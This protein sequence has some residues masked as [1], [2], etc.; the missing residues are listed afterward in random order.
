MPC[1]FESSNSKGYFTFVAFIRKDWN[2]SERWWTTT[3][4]GRWTSLSS[5]AAAGPE[6]LPQLCGVRAPTTLSRASRSPCQAEQP[7]AQKRSHSYAGYAPHDPFS[8]HRDE[9]IRRGGCGAL[10]EA[11]PGLPAR[12]VRPG[13]RRRA[14]ANR[15][16]WW[17]CPPPSRPPDI[18][19]MFL[20][21]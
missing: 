6:A 13:W 14:R 4:T 9:C 17:G 20:D 21:T 19:R 7:R 3:G 5:R 16:C 11:G 10:G 8:G 15:P 12:E 1:D 18:P 2:V